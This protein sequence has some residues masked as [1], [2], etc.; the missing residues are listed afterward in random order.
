MR[1]KIHDLMLNVLTDTHGDVVEC[2]LCGPGARVPAPKP[3]P[4][5]R[6]KPDCTIMTATGDPGVALRGSDAALAPLSAL[7]DEL[8]RALQP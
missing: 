6:P 3:K 8:R 5:P 2:R 7:R 4:S 1:F